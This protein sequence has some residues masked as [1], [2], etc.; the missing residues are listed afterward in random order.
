MTN[1]F[2]ELSNEVIRV[3][4]EKKNYSIKNRKSILP[5]AEPL[6]GLKSCGSFFRMG[7]ID[8]MFDGHRNGDTIMY[9]IKDHGASIKSLRH[10]PL[11]FSPLPQKNE[12]VLTAM[13]HDRPE[14]LLA[15]FTLAMDLIFQRIPNEEELEQEAGSQTALHFSQAATW[16]LP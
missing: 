3:L 8:D 7:K 9:F 13:D 5:V 14:D 12:R 11:P 15:S 16:Q 6:L 10:P 4:H 2:V 1:R